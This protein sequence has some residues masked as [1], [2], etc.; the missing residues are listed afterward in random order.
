MYGVSLFFASIADIFILLCLVELALSLLRALGK[1]T[2]NY[3][4]IRYSNFVV[5]AVLFVLAIVALAESESF[6][7]GFLDENNPSW[8]T[9]GKLYGAYRIIYWIISLGLVFLSAFVLYGSM[10]KKEQQNVGKVSYT[11]WL[12]SSVP[13]VLHLSPLPTPS[14][15]I[16]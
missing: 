10:R 15:L 16:H 8:T 9:A 12:L 13:P 2:P 7:T 3:G 14:K 11:H 5:M 1:H 6:A 4:I